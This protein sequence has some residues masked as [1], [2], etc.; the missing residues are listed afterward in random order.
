M[1]SGNEAYNQILN[2]LKANAE[3]FLCA[4]IQKNGESNIAVTPGSRN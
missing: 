3:F 1:N 4:C 2:Q